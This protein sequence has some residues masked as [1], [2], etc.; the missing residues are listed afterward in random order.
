MTRRQRC[1]V[2]CTA[3]LPGKH[4]PPAVSIRLRD[5]APATRRPGPQPGVHGNPL[6]A[7]D[8][9]TQAIPHRDPLAAIRATQALRGRYAARRFSVT[10]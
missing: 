8:P 1:G 7:V 6:V 10:A 2:V 3:R 4:L 5:P 9:Q